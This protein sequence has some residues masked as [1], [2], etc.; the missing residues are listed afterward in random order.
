[1][2]VTVPIQV[3]ISDKQIEDALDKVLE[4]NDYVKVIRCKN[5]IHCGFCGDRTNLEI[6][7]FNGYC[8]RGEVKGGEK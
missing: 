1:M 3:T 5:C 8:S 4:E 7:G 6:M 2:D